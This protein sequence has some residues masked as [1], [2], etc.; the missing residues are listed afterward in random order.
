[1]TEPRH[2][3]AVDVRPLGSMIEPFLARLAGGAKRFIRECHN[4]LRRPDVCSAGL[5]K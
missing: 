5:D 1:M 3:T 4:T 2:A